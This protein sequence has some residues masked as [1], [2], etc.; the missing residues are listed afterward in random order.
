MGVKLA[1]NSFG[2]LAAG[3]ASGA[4]SITLTTGQGSRF[5]TLGAGDY[6]FATLIDT[7]NNLEI[8]KCTARATDVLTVVRAQENTT[9]RAYSAGDRIEIRVTA[10][11]LIDAGQNFDN[12]ASGL[13]ATTTQAALDELANGRFIYDSVTY[14]TNTTLSTADN[15]KLVIASGANT[16]LTLPAP[17]EGIVFALMNVGSGYVVI[18]AASS[19][20]RIG[21]YVG[22]TILPAGGSI[23]LGSNGTNWIIAAG[24]PKVNVRATTYTSSGT[25]TKPTLCNAILV[26]LYGATGGTSSAAPQNKNG[27]GGGGY[28][29]KLYLSPAAS[30]SFTL[31]AGGIEGSGAGGTT[32][33]DTMSITGSNYANTNTAG[34]VA[35]G[36]AFNANG[37]AGGTGGGCGGGGGG[38]GTR[39]GVGG[40]GGNG[41]TT[42]PGGGGGTGGNAG[43]TNNG[44]GGAAATA[45]SGS[46][47]SLSTNYR[48]DT[49]V[50]MAGA[51]SK[52]STS[53]CPGASG[54]VA[55]SSSF[56]DDSFNI[57][58]STCGQGRGG[59][60]NGYSFSSAG[61]G[62]VVTIVEFY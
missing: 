29:E 30:Y 58:T 19:S 31:G 34:G 24:G 10:Q 25:W 8:V 55:V 50:Y 57:G 61:I 15:Y 40:A 42:L 43:G 18:S 38:S 59:F 14:S 4:T 6:F 7:S 33:F 56:F 52:S 35:S 45:P 12:T 17:A 37:G 60:S 32:T 27:S 26:C 51:S 22:S 47:Y 36:G 13:A 21:G 20:T 39:A 16:R 9:A 2:T 3:I 46:A 54:L 11:G 62:G 48:L 28:S 1:N 23:I 44:T 41:G 49:E 5:P 53:S